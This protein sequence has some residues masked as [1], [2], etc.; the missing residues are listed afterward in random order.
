[1]F[2]NRKII[3][4]TKHQKEKVIAPLL[5]KHLEVECFVPKNFDSDRLGTF[6]GEVER[7]DD[8][9]TTLRKKC[10]M[11]MD[12]NNYDLG[13]AS[14]G[15]FG[16][17]PSLY[18]VP[19]NDEFI[20]LIDK[21]NN[22][23]IIAREISTNTNFY[24]DTITSETDLKLLAN[25]VSFPTHGLILRK[26]KYD[27]NTIYKGITDWDL[28]T[29]IFHELMNQFGSVYIETDMRAMMNPTRMNIIEK[30]T[31][32]LI[33]KIKSKCPMCKT[34][35]FSITESKQ[36]LPC[37]NCQLPTRSVLSYLY[38]CN[39]CDFKKEEKFPNNKTTEA[40]MYCDYCNP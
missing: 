32:K 7:L 14:E 12:E 30:A 8:P 16:A 10:L 37:E 17:H 25:K 9:I 4:A 34:P 22:I 24:A 39:K 11:A 40:A 29:N 23:E 1:M 2:S 36:G 5:E 31:G 18:F 35:G 27:Y 28:L 19:A 26:S 13:I 21:K 6:S 3:I 15:S 33:E 20:I 38:T